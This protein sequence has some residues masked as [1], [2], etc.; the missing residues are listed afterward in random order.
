MVALDIQLLWTS[1]YRTHPATCGLDKNCDVAMLAYVRGQCHADYVS[2]EGAVETVMV[3][4]YCR[5][6]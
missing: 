2:K 5:L 4:I 6:D 1:L 3:V